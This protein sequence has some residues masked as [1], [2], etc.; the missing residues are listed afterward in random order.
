VKMLIRTEASPDIGHG[1]VMRCCALAD[2]ARDHNIK[3]FFQR[4]DSY[5][6]NL[7]ETMGEQLAPADDTTLI[8]QWIVRDYREGSSKAEVASE[9]KQGSVVLL[10][11]DLGLARIEASIV[12]DALMTKARSECLPHSVHTRYL[13]GLDYVPLRRQFSTT[14]ASARPGLQATGRLFVSFGGGDLSTVTQRYIEALNQ[15]GF[16]GP[17]SIVSNGAENIRALKQLTLSWDNTDIFDYLPNMAAEMGKCDLV[18]S[19]LGITQFEAF[20]LGLGCMLIEPTVAHETL[21]RE[22][23]QAYQ[24]WPAVEF[25]MASEVDFTVAAKQT[26]NRLKNQHWLREQGKRGAELVKGIGA[27]KIIQA[28]LDAANG[29]LSHL[30]CVTTE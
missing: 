8:P 24:P 18:A 16:K 7:L 9:V 11:D 22:L 23:E 6:D 12:T 14:A 26:I 10:F 21:S 30:D 15:A 20:S 28:L 1:H 4:S 19:K 2:A 17:A 29:S 5:T 27:K 13:Y 25:G 3:V